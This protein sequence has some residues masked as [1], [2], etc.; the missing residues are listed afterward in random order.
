M[1]P[2][3]EYVPSTKTYTLTVRDGKFKPDTIE[4]FLGDTAIV[5][6][7]NSKGLYK[8]HDEIGNR[9][10]LLKPN[11]VYILEFQADREGQFILGCTEHCV[12]PIRADIS[13]RKPYRL[14]C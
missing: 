5:T 7:R 4:A 9:S 8:I 13:V 2:Y 11:D 14:L 10:I 1:V 3:P 12:D 6:L